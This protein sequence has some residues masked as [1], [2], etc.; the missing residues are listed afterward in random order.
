MG[1]LKCPG[2]KTCMR[3]ERWWGGMMRRTMSTFDSSD[4][5][6][7]YSG[8]VG[9]NSVQTLSE[10]SLLPVTINDLL[11][12]FSLTTMRSSLSTSTTLVLRSQDNR[13]YLCGLRRRECTYR[14][15]NPRF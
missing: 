7:G 4:E 9:R 6:Q 13:L 12:H 15:L 2:K 10:W 3:K 14:I 5:K 11:G 1:F 8:S